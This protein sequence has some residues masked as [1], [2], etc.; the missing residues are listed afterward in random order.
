MGLSVF[1]GKQERKLASATEFT[2]HP[3]FAA[4]GLHESSRDSK[5]Q[6]HSSAVH[7]AIVWDLKEVTEDLLVIFR[8]NSW[9]GIGNADAHGVWGAEDLFAPLTDLRRG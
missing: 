5:A 7:L 1:E 9:A 3:N 8:R 4:M 6:T 2:L